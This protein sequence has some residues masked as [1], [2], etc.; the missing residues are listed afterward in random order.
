MSSGSLTFTCTGV[1]WNSPAPVCTFLSL[2]STT[3]SQC[4]ASP[5]SVTLNGGNFVN[6]PSITV[7]IG[8]NTCSSPSYVS[9]SA[10]SCSLSY[11]ASYTGGTVS[12]TINSVAAS[13]SPTLSILPSITSIT[14]NP[15]TASPCSVNI[16]GANFAS[17]VTTV[18]IGGSSCGSAAY[19]SA[20][21]VTCSYSYTTSGGG[22]VSV[23]NN[24]NT[25]SGSVS[26]N[27]GCLSLFT[28]IANSNA[29]TC[30]NSFAPGSCNIVCISH[31]IVTSGSTSATCSITGVWT[32]TPTA[33]CSPLTISSITSASPPCVV[34]P[35][36]VTVTG[37]NFVPPGSIGINIGGSPCSSPQYL[38]ST[39]ASCSYSWSTAGGGGAVV[40]TNN[41]VT[42]T[43]S[44]TLAVGCL[45]ASTLSL[46]ANANVGSC[47]NNFAPN[48]GCNIA[49]N[50]GSGYALTAGSYSATCSN[51]GTWSAPT[52][53]CTHLTISSVSPNPCTSTPCAVA[54]TGTGFTGFVATDTLTVTIGG[55]SCSSVSVISATTIH[56]TYAFSNPGG[57]AVVLTDTTQG[58]TATGSPTM[59]VACLSLFTAIANS[60]YG[61]CTNNFAP[62]S[63]SIVC[64]SN[65]IVTSGS[66]S[67]TCSNA[68]VWTSPTA[69]CSLLQIFS[70]SPTSC[71]DPCTL[72]IAGQ[73]FV[74]G[75]ISVT[76]AGSYT[77]PSCTYINPTMVTCPFSP[78]GQVGATSANQAIT[79]TDNGVSA[80]GSLSFSVLCDTPIVLPASPSGEAA[81]QNQST[82]GNV[83]AA[84]LYQGET[85]SVAC[86]PG[87][88]LNDGNL[89][90]TCRGFNITATTVAPV[91]G[92]F[93]CKSDFTVT[94]LPD[95]TLGSCNLSFPSY[96]NC[97]PGCQP[98]Y[99]DFQTPA[100]AYCELGS[101]SVFG[102]CTHSMS[103]SHS[104]SMSVSSSR[105][106]SSSHSMSDSSSQSDS[107]SLS[108]SRSGSSSQ[109]RSQS[110]SMSISQSESLELLPT[111]TS[112][113]PI[114]MIEG[115]NITLT[116][117]GYH[118]YHIESVFV[119]SY[120]CRRIT[121]NNNYIECIMDMTAIPPPLTPGYTYP[122][123][124]TNDQKHYS[125]QGFFIDPR[126]H[127]ASI[128]T[129]V[130]VAP[131]L[132]ISANDVVYVTSSSSLNSSA[133]VLNMTLAG[134]SCLAS[135][136][137]ESFD[138]VNTTRYSY[139]TFVVPNLDARLNMQSGT[140]A[141]WSAQVLMRFYAS[142]PFYGVV[143]NL[144]P[145]Y[146]QPNITYTIVASVT[147]ICPETIR[148]NGNTTVFVRG[149][150]FVFTPT[151]RC[152]FTVDGN[153]TLSFVPAQADSTQV[154]C[155][156][157]WPL[158]SKPNSL[159]NFSLSNSGLTTSSSRESILV[160]LQSPCA[161]EKPLSFPVYDSAHGV[162]NCI[163]PAGS[164]DKTTLCQLCQNGFY[165]GSVG[166][167]SC[168][169]C[170]LNQD[171]NRVTGSL[172]S[173]ACFCKPNFYFD[174]SEQKCVACT[175]GMSCPGGG[176]VD[177]AKGFWRPSASSGVILP[178]PGG[179]AAC[180]G[181]SG[182]NLCADGY[183]G[184]LCTVCAKGYSKTNSYSCVSCPN[185]GANYFFLVV[186]ILFTIF[187]IYMMLRAA[188]RYV[189]TAEMS[190]PGHADT[191][192]TTRRPFTASLD[193]S[194]Q[195]SQSSHS[196]LLSRPLDGADANAL[197]KITVNYLQVL[198]YIGRVNANWSSEAATFFGV[199]GQATLTPNFISLQ[200]ALTWTFYQ[201]LV[202]MYISPVIIIGLIIAIFVA[203][204]LLFIRRWRDWKDS[205]NDFQMAVMLLL[206]LMHPSITLEVLSSI[207]CQDVAGTFYL[208]ADMSVDCASSTYMR[209]RTFS[210]VYL[211]V[212]VLGALALVTFRLVMN[213]R[214]GKLFAS[215]SNR[216]YVFLH[217][218]F[219]K[220]LYFW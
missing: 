67:A 80:V 105:S 77:P 136:L 173:S 65:Y 112:I 88:G 121:H 57:G 171:T 145:E 137:G 53:T 107:L 199:V 193:Q 82:C 3:P 108:R 150:N 21:V 123:N 17:A 97:T 7:T 203:Q 8:G 20:T 219:K 158:Q 48:A 149:T 169:A 166:A 207:P 153:T 117:N 1:T 83:T 178:C 205:L 95:S 175:D 74:S 218:G 141:T 179:S 159:A 180:A 92:P 198:F 114:S 130:S 86:N 81:T 128:F 102:E 98:A 13:G 156:I 125:F 52:A 68:G 129:A 78:V 181:G 206:Y 103:E 42:A 16:N 100:R 161:S 143:N 144:L 176:V 170:P 31:Y 187:I 212:Y 190:E 55:S 217:K 24:G 197:A 186:L 147:S 184:P 109:S 40:L 110:A 37:N 9:P 192:Q 4:T 172:S 152:I 202:F 213:H 28:A 132:Y 115:D 133:Y 22:T 50:I 61:T 157:Y 142:I 99:V 167:P 29:G 189:D 94:Q 155:L 66:T 124:V 116:I 44:V 168:I 23:I 84:P 208:V 51:T 54:V 59:T 220:S 91:C 38:T 64:L 126:P 183:A 39:T 191:P 71:A 60:N 177:I 27:V 63:C 131:A 201:K 15:C 185:P 182:A 10:I 211:F 70:V 62:G 148:I 138:F 12:L 101:W 76:V 194:S 58:V 47:T 90:Y 41:G 200:C 188:K 43:G 195:S 162:T 120:D 209:Y 49:C 140:S 216:K 111:I 215:D 146:D 85:C 93:Q 87:H 214:S 204:H 14:P 72:N 33:V 2:S 35:C 160:T 96:T 75:S 163:C 79:L 6:T 135:L 104:K 164:A 210:L 174:S 30:T 69:T 36:T 119:G 32:T 46:P 106:L 113:S 89:S 11:T 127:V 19:S 5:C 154:I 18:T 165:Q 196:Q 34:S 122:V 56:C 25:A 151:L 45:L 26:L 134:V 73:N 139:W 118:F